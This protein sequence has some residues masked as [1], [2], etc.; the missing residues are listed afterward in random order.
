M[1]FSGVIH[2]QFGDSLSIHLRLDMHAHIP[3]GLYIAH[4]CRWRRHYFF[5]QCSGLCSIVTSLVQAQVYPS[6]FCC[7]ASFRQSSSMDNNDKTVKRFK[8]EKVSGRNAICICTYI[9]VCIILVYFL[10]QQHLSEEVWGIRRSGLHPLFLAYLMSLATGYYLGFYAE[11]R[12]SFA[13][14][15]SKSWRSGVFT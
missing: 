1:L 2:L 12:A 5:V 14:S 3:I 13:P 9:Y 8:I 11:E 7:L 4:C 15:L 6:T 10:H